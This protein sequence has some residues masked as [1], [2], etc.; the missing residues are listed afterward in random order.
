MTLS[1]KRRFKS[2]LQPANPSLLPILLIAAITTSSL[3]IIGSIGSLVSSSTQKTPH[4]VVDTEGNP[5]PI[6]L[7]A[8]N[9]DPK[10][11]RNYA[12]RK[13]YDIFDWRGLLPPD[14]E[15]PEEIG[16]PKR[17]PG[18]EIKVGESSTRKIT[19]STWKAALAFEEPF[20]SGFIPMLAKLTPS[21]VFQGAAQGAF[22]PLAV[23]VPESLG[24]GR[25]RV[26]V[27][28]VLMLF[29]KGSNTPNQIPVKYDVF[30]REV[31]SFEVQSKDPKVLA[32][33]NKVWKGLPKSLQEQVTVSELAKAIYESRNGF[34]VITMREVQ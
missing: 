20:A 8:S 30:L 10:R 23:D 34:T 24:N 7:V 11:A 15:K 14:P 16:N 27:V 32:K 5:H 6:K 4:Y 33:A 21:E 2:L 1:S 9:S 3:S 22:S 18:V 31:D 12:S 13:I 29:E 25:W 17:D 28:G 26:R 19:T